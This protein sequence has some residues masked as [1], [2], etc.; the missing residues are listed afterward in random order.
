MRKSEIKR[1]RHIEIGSER[2]YLLKSYK[3]AYLS[4]IYYVTGTVLVWQ[5]EKKTTFQRHINFLTYKTCKFNLYAKITNIISHAKDVIEL[6]VLRSL[7]GMHTCNSMYIYKREAKEVLRWE[8]ERECEE[9]S[10]DWN[11]VHRRQGISECPAA[12]RNWKRQGKIL[13][14]S[15]LREWSTTWTLI[16][17]F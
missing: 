17:D 8:R 14:H 15:L 12:T 6:R 11:E 10:R 13:F 1:Q 9:G 4:N 16:L 3:P 5:A 2:E 7:S